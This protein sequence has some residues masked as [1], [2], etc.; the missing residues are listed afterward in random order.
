MNRQ[1][2]YPGT[3]I[4]LLI[5]TFAACKKEEQIT[6]KEFAKRE[7]FIDVLVDIHLMDGVTQDRKFGRMYDVDSVD[8]LTPILEKHQ[9]SRQMFDTTLFV[10][11][12]K[13]E[14]LD[15]VYNEVLIKL[16]VMLDE[17]NKEEPSSTPES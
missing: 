6:G 7:V 8:I 17:N 4:L 3:L 10:Y 2:R 15:A 1:L 5:L 9:I 12:R 11:S 16:N 14:L 13:P